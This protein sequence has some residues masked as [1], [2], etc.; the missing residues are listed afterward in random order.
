MSRTGNP[1]TALRELI[2]EIIRVSPRTASLSVALLLFVTLAEGVGLLLLGPLLERVLVIEENPLPRAGGWLTAALG[3][4][5]LEVTLGSVLGLFVAIAVLRALAQH[6]RVRT[7]EIVREDVVESYRSRL[8]RAI[9][10]AEWRYLVTRAPSHFVH[11]L[12]GEVSRVGQAVTNLTDLAVAVVVSTVYVGL[13]LRTAPTLTFLVLV[14]AIVLAFAVRREFDLARSLGEDGAVVRRHMHQTI[15]EQLASLKTAR[16]YGAVERQLEEVEQLSRDA[17]EISKTAV[18]ADSRF[19]Q[20]LEVGSTILLAV[21]VYV[22]ATVLEIPPALLLVVMFVF[23]RLMPRIIQIYRLVRSLKMIL[24][25]VADLQARVRECTEAAEAPTVPGRP[26]A[27]ASR[28]CFNDVS[29]SY[30]RRGDK[31]AVSALNLQ[32]DAGKTTAIVGASGSGKS[33]VADLLTGLLTPSSGQINIDGRPLT[34]EGLA[35][36]RSQIGFVPQDTFLFHDTLRANLAWARTGVTDEAIWEA[37]RLASAD[38]F[39]ADLPTGLD[40]IIGERG[41]LLSGGERQRVAIARALLRSPSILVL[42]EATSSLDVEHEH[43]I[44]EAIDSL[45]HRLTLVVITHRLT[46]I[47]HADV[48]HVMEDGVIVQSGTWEQLQQEPSGPFHSFAR[49]LDVAGGMA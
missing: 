43:R 7:L 12:S 37:L 33:T 6:W 8:H 9:A 41:V 34:A 36:W 39:V 31:A 18:L 4:I 32:I 44:Q 40:T 47:R 29:F 15:S 30:L 20:S 45:H 22:A 42:D 16:V 21:V 28:L 17:R 27:F 11:A 3:A 10:G 46:T 48:I 49:R 35:S 23:A 38:Q 2:A 25:I 5:G 19:Q 24:P 1:K 26:I 14:S 13:A